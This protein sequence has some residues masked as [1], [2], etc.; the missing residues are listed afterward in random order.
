M[1]RFRQHR[2]MGVVFR[3][4]A[5][6]GRA[7]N[8]YVFDA[9]IESGTLRDCRLKRVEIHRHQI[10]RRNPMRFHLRQMLSQIAPAQNAAMHL[11]HERFH[12]PIK[13]F[14][15]ARMVRYILHRHARLAQRLGGAA[16]GENL[17]PTRRQETAKFN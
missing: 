9:I 4:A 14:R 8:I 13:D 5:D 11:R 7:A 10:N 15:K 12:A 1:R 16:G 3:R 17:H 6:H 2:D